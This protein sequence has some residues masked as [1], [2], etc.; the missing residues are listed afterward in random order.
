MCT[1]CSGCFVMAL[2]AF[3]TPESHN[4]LASEGLRRGALIYRISGTS[5]GSTFCAQ[6]ESL[7]ISRSK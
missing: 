4:A 7:Q 5:W 2:G 6:A 3:G 1:G